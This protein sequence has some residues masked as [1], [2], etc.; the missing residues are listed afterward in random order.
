MYPSLFRDYVLL[1]TLLLTGWQTGFGQPVNIGIPP[2]RNFSNKV[3]K[4]GTQN[5][6]AAQDSRGVIYWANNNGVLKYDGTNWS[7][8]P[9]ANNTIVRSV[10]IDK[11]GR[12]YAGAQSEFGLFIPSANGHLVYH[13]LV[14]LL[15]PQ[16]RSFED[17]WDIT[18]VD[19][20]VFFRTNHMVF[21]YSGQQIKVYPLAHEVHSMFAVPSGLII[22]Q[23]SSSL[24]VFRNNAFQPFMQIPGLHSAVT[25]VL[26]WQ[27]DTIILSSLKNGLFYLTENTCGKWKTSF[28]H[29]LMENRIYSSTI[30][31][32]GNLAIGTSL[33]GLIVIDQKRRM[34][35]HIT[36]KMGLQNNNILH[37]FSDRAGNV[38]LGLDNGIDCV[39][40]DSP[41]SSIFPDGEMQAT[42]YSAV[43][44]DQ[45]LYLGVSNGAYVSAWKPYYD[46][47]EGSMFSK[48]SSSDGQVW[49]LN[50]VDGTLLMG[51]HEGAF[52]LEGSQAKRLSAEQGAWTFV[53]VASDYMLGGTYTGLVLYRKENNQWVFDRKLTGLEESCRIMVKDQDGSVWVSH[54]YRGLYHIKW[55]PEDK[56]HPEI[57]FYNQEN[58]LPTNLN[59]YV[60]EIAGK[61]VFTTEKGVFHFDP[62]TGKFIPAEDFNRQFG[63]NNRVKYLR[64]DGKGNV[65]FVTD[66]ETGILLVDDFG[67]KKEVQK[68]VFPELANKLVGGF[69]FLYPVDDRNVIIGSEQ[70]FIHYTP[71]NANEADTT[72][73]II[74]SNITAGGA[75]DS[76]LF[77][78][79]QPVHE[80]GDDEDIQVLDAGMNNLSFSFSATD[81]KNPGLIEYR[82]Q[83]EGLD[84]NWSAWSAES[85][86]NYTNL[87]P[88][89]YTFHVQARIKDAYESNIVTYSFRI[90][91]PW[92]KS[93]VALVVYGLGFVGFFAGFIRRQR[94]RFESEKAQMTESHQQIEA[95]HLKAVEQSRAAL[96]EIQNE[97]LEAEITY[98]NQELAL[99]TMHLVQKAEILLTV[100]EG[101]NQILEKSQHPGVNKEVQQLLNLL[102]FDVKLDEDWEHFAYHFDQVHVNF[103]K[104]L[105]ERFPQLSANDCKLCA[106]LRMNLSTKEIAPLMNISVRGVEGSRYRLR[107]KLNLPNDANLTEFMLNLPPTVTHPANTIPE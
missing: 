4:A 55:S 68:K 53:Q 66:K 63:T 13:S 86:K 6:D 43:V 44:F 23:D 91:P 64:E 38:W 54:P 83:L 72:L 30:L 46:P 58:G 60:F 2:M 96:S 100:Q 102:N 88:G 50:A 29:V 3:Y 20:E 93:K 67:L 18:I 41:F 101:L 62:A 76:L 77:G 92:Y 75:G 97:K 81:Y 84:E 11:S 25:G 105:R 5:W 47:Q 70:G 10:A 31:P 15:P 1:F 12:L 42:G 79:Y 8:L 49:S 45:H 22:Q 69:E 82:V 103:L 32:D 16:H 99:T 74:L 9:V 39:I 24:S 73:Q 17:V 7:C 61:A 36:R 104:H 21:Q 51:H 87:G 106:Y 89:N 52:Q 57:N 56:Y 71:A 28:D 26:P 85:R 59:N 98:K 78:G 19:G 65:W 33:D 34:S 80:E 40:L 95:A 94:Q 14:D 27:G 35:R 107:R 48:V 90:R 37:T